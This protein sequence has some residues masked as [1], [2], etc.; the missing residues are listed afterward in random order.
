MQVK[1]EHCLKHLDSVLSIFKTITKF[2]K[3]VK[4][5]ENKMSIITPPPNQSV[6]TENLSQ[7]SRGKNISDKLHH[8]TAQLVNSKM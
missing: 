5:L 3:L 8:E 7:D 4:K 2:Q 6:K 1:V